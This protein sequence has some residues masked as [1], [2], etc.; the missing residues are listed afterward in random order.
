MTLEFGTTQPAWQQ[1]ILP[2]LVL[3]NT[4]LDASATYK[5]LVQS[6]RRGQADPVAIWVYDNSPVPQVFTTNTASL[7]TY[8]HDRNNRGIAAAYNWALDIAQSLGYRWLLL[9][10]QDTQLPSNFLERS[11]LQLSEYDGDGTVVA[12]VP[13]VRGAG[14]I[15]SPKRV[16]LCGLRPLP[17]LRPGVRN[18][19]IMAIN[20]GSA[21]RCDFVRSIGGFN[22]MYRL[23]FLDHWLFHQVYASGRKAAISDCYID[24]SLSVQDYRHSVSTERYKSI[25][26][27]EATF[28]LTY[29]SYFA[30]LIYLFRLLLRTM[31]FV[32]VRN[33]FR[34][35]AMTV[36][37]L[38]R[39]VVAP[40]TE[41]SDAQHQIH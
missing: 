20:S 40:G 41:V 6:G 36:S 34:M 29:K 35:A 12:L 24:H 38:L 31:K 23:D 32:L 4:K 7:I 3:Y 10:D 21:I 11:L 30:R 19:E 37:V 13:V 17:C 5:T 27:A 18:T 39:I 8:R 1:L 14:S 16:A 33:R 2:V 22:S 9:L 15:V 26:A 28:V 25:L